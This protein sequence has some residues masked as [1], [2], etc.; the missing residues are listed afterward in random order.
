[1]EGFFCLVVVVAGLFCLLKVC[2]R[3][4]PAFQALQRERKEKEA[5]ELI[6]SVAKRRA[7]LERRERDRLQ[8][9]KARKAWVSEK[10][11]EIEKTRKA[12]ARKKARL[13]KT[14]SYLSSIDPFELE[15]LCLILFAKLGYEAKPTPRSHDNGVDGFL[16]KGGR[17]TILQ[18]KRYQ[19][20]IGEPAMRDLLGAM[21]HFSASEAI[22]VTTGRLTS[23]ALKWIRG[24]PIR[25][26]GR[27]ELAA[28]IKSNIGEADL[29]ATGS[30]LPEIPPPVNCPKCGYPLEKRLEPFKRK[31][32][33][34]YLVCSKGNSCSYRKRLT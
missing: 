25:V 22:I 18:C 20:V 32:S 26:I 9:E 10:L 30:G 14:E 19:G 15:N 12:D 16:R 7:W 6:E 13:L 31:S 1:M 29:I 11:K 34:I 4:D 8:Q 28:L 2:A 23:Q 21:K 5:R 24:K 27:S 3:P 17:L 33:A